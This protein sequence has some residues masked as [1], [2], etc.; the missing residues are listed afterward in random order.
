MV[1]QQQERVAPPS[2]F[3]V[4]GLVPSDPETVG[5]DCGWRHRKAPAVRELWREG[6]GATGIV[7]EFLEDTSVGL[8]LSAGW[9]ERPERRSERGRGVRGG[10]PPGGRPRYPVTTGGLEGGSCLF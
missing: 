6:S 4:P 3:R 2:L 10:G 7:L 9:Q 8:R 5:K 1:W